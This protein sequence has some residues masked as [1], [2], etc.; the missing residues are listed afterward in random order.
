MMSDEEL[1]QLQDELVEARAE[2]E[3]LRVTAAD[4]EARAAHLESQLAELREELSRAQE[5]GDARA[6]ELSAASERAAA[7][8][9]QVRSAAGRYRELL[10][11]HAPELPEELVAGETVEAI[12]ESLSRARETVAKVRGHLESQAL[13]ARVPVGAPPRSAPGHAALSTEDKIGL[14]LGKH[15][16]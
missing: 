4:R 2:L 13:A 3:G 9:A 8:D 14:G 6:Q 5:D 15:G 1:T 12:E 11:Q 10:L 7:L 16:G